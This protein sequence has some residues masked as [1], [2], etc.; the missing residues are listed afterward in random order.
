MASV[1]NKNTYSHYCQQ[2]KAIMT[3]VL[4]ISDYVLLS[5]LN[6]FNI[7]MLNIKNKF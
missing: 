1:E 6:I 7:V 4:S 2:G 3:A 5:N